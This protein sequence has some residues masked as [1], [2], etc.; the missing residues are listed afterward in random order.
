MQAILDLPFGVH[1]RIEYKL[2]KCFMDS[3]FGN[4]NWTMDEQIGVMEILKN[5]YK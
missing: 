2:N 1:S 3:I 5:E 4:N